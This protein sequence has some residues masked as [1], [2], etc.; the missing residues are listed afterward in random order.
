MVFYLRSCCYTVTINHLKPRVQLQNGNLI[1]QHHDNHELA[2]LAIA[3]TS[4]NS[5][6]LFDSVTSHHIAIDRSYLSFH[7]TYDGFDDIVIGDG[8]SLS[9]THTGS[10]SLYTLLH[11]FYLNNIFCVLTTK[12]NLI[13]VFQFCQSNNT[14]IE[15]FSTSFIVKDLRIW[16]TFFVGSN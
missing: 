1:Q 15:F 14:S 9:I 16:G 7:T 3:N 11:T 6:W 12:K 5:S 13:Y 4:T 2:N 8:I 10:K